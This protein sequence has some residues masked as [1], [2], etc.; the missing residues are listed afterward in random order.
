MKKVNS[1]SRETDYLFKLWT[2]GEKGDLHY[3][4]RIIIKLLIV[5][6]NSSIDK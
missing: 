4:L 3:Q 2:V 1:N 6:N 5:A